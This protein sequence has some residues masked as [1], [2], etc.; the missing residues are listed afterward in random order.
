MDFAQLF[1][2]FFQSV[3]CGTAAVFALIGIVGIRTPRRSPAM[4][5]RKPSR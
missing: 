5:P 3:A 2:G 4:I 1:A